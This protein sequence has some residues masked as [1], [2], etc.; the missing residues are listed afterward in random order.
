VSQTPEPFVQG[1]ADGLRAMLEWPTTL[2]TQLALAQRQMLESGAA[3]QRTCAAAY[4]DAWERWLS[5]FA[6]GARIDD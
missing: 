1:A 5:I 3:W 6:G 4:E 2:G